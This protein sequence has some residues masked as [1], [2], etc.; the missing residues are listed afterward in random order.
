MDTFV[1]GIGRLPEHQLMA[2]FERA[3]PLER[4]IQASPIDAVNA[5]LSVSGR[6][7]RRAERKP[8]PVRSGFQYLSDTAWL[9]AQNAG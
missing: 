8:D 5:A 2:A 7:I 3:R 4:M 9:V 1:A 6:P